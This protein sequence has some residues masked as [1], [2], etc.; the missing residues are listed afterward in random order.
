MSSRLVFVEKS[1]PLPSYRI[2][3]VTQLHQ[4]KSL[5]KVVKFELK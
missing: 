5:I 4:A 3:E 1:L 2:P